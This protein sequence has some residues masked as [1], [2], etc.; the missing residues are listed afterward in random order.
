MSDEQS[1][2]L[3]YKFTDRAGNLVY[4]R[5]ALDDYKTQHDKLGEVRVPPDTHEPD[6]NERIKEDWREADTKV[7]GHGTG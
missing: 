7:E 1:Y 2:C 3:I 5:Y 6:I 4:H